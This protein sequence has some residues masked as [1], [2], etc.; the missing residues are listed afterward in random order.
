MHSKRVKASLEYRCGQKRS[1][2][3]RNPEPVPPF[4]SERPEQVKLLLDTQGPQVSENPG[5]CNIHIRD[6]KHRG[7]NVVPADLVPVE[8]DHDCQKNESSGKNAERTSRIK[9]RQTDGGTFLI[10]AK[11]K[12]G[13]QI[14]RQHEEDEHPHRA[15]SAQEFCRD[16]LPFDK[17]TQHHQRNGDRTKTVQRWD[18]SFSHKIRFDRTGRTEGAARVMPLSVPQQ[19]EWKTELAISTSRCT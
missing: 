4:Q 7:G 14:S 15:V 3:D 5:P 9:I 19:C 18:S 13:N 8:N 10:L 16:V 11:Q 1:Q 6:I 17:V 2:H 12:I